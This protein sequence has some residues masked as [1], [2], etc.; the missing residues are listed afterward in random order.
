MKFS[1]IV[2]MNFK[3]TLTPNNLRNKSQL[4]QFSNQRLEIQMFSNCK[5]KLQVFSY[6]KL[7]IQMF[8]NY[9]PKLQV[10][11]YCKLELQMFSSSKPKLQMIL[12]KLNSN[13]SIFLTL[14][15]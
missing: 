4:Q 13:V 9:K 14:T 12:K 11:S 6:C 2:N 5:P 7:E 3:Y 10:Y 15:S 8:S 1:T